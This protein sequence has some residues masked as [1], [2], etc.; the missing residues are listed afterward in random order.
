MDLAGAGAGVLVVSEDLDEL[1]EIAD[2][3]AVLS[4]GKLSPPMPVA[5]ATVEGIGLL[6][7]GAERV[8]H[9]PAA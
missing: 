6:M 8:A 1:L 4:G 5:E 9:A 3:I 7:G 2:R